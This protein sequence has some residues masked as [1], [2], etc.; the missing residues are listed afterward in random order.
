MGRVL[1]NRHLER[2]VGREDELAAQAETVGRDYAAARE[3]ADFDVAAVIAG[4]LAH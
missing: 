2:W 3:R 4:E 1:S